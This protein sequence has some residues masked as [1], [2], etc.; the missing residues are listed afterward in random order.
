MKTALL[1]LSFICTAAFA[2]DQ[3]PTRAVIHTTAGDINLTLFPKTAPATVANF[4]KLAQAKFFD[5][6]TF[7]RVVPGFVIQGGDPNT[8]K[9]ATG[10]PGTGTQLDAKGN[11]LLIK[12]EV[13]AANPE[14][15]TPGTLAMARGPDLNSASCQFYVTLAAT[16]SLDGQYTVFGRV[17]G[18]ADLAVA[19]K[20]K[21]DDRMT[22]EIIDPTDKKAVPAAADAPAT[23]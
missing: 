11:P 15:H 20:V 12:A 13:G 9:G 2:A 6:S 19:L 8:K 5:G 4:V 23:K 1:V 22:V 18:E 14:K 16:P 17:V 21:A 10:Q 7:H 3:S